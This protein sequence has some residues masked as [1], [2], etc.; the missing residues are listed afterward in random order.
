MK[1]EK[2]VNEKNRESIKN[3]SM[4]GNLVIGGFLLLVLIMII[5]VLTGNYN[6][7]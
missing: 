5:A 3:Q 7:L 2:E 6:S 1:K 4:Q